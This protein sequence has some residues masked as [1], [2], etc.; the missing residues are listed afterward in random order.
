MPNTKIKTISQLLVII[1]LA[2]IVSACGRGEKDEATK[3]ST[4]AITTTT[5]HP[6]ITSEVQL[7]AIAFYNNDSTTD[8]T[9]SSSWQSSDEK[10][11]TINTTGLVTFLDAGE[12]TIS[13]EFN[14]KSGSHK[15]DVSPQPSI[16]TINIS[17]SSLEITET[18]VVTLSATG[19][20]TD[21]STVTDQQ[22]FEWRSSDEEIATIDNSEENKGVLTAKKYGTVT[23]IASS[24][25]IEGQMELTIQPEVTGINMDDSTLYLNLGDEKFVEVRAD[26]SN[27]EQ[28]LIT[29][30]L[31]WSYSLTETNTKEKEVLEIQRSGNVLL[32]KPGVTQVTATFISNT[33]QTFQASRTIVVEEPLNLFVAD[34][35]NQTIELNWLAVQDATEYKIYWS[36]EAN[37]TLENTTVVTIEDAT[38]F[39][40]SDVDK[41]QIYYYR[42]SFTR[43]GEESEP[44]PE[45][46]V[47]AH[48]GQWLNKQ[49]LA[50]FTDNA[51]G[52][53]QNAASVIHNDSIFVFGGRFY[54][55]NPETT[56]V[57]ESLP[58]VSSEVLEYR[59]SDDQWFP[60]SSLT[61]AREYA[62]ACI[63]QDMAFVIGGLDETDSALDLGTIS[64]F[65][66]VNGVWHEVNTSLAGTIL[67][68][69]SCNIIDN[70][71]YI[72]G[73]KNVDTA[74]NSVY[75]FDLLSVAPDAALQISALT[76]MNGARYNHSSTVLD[77]KIYVAG[78]QSGDDTL[79]TVEVYDPVENSWNDLKTMVNARHSFKLLSH[80]G[81]IYTIGGQSARLTTE[82]E[83][84][85]IASDNW[86]VNS[87]LPFTNHSFIGEI[88]NNIFYLFGGDKDLVS[89]SGGAAEHM[90]FS[91]TTNTWYPHPAAPTT[92]SSKGVRDFTSAALNDKLYLIGG[93]TET[94][95]SVS[96]V[97]AFDFISNKW[98]YDP[99]SSESINPDTLEIA[100]S[101]ATAVT[102]NNKIY[103]IGGKNDN[104]YLDTIEVYDPIGNLWSMS[105]GTLQEARSEACAVLFEQQ[106]YIFGGRDAGGL[107]SYE[108]FDPISE[109]STILGNT[110]QGIG[111]GCAVVNDKIY[112]IGGGEYNP[113]NNTV[114]ATDSFRVYTPAINHWGP[115]PTIIHDNKIIHPAVSVLNNRIYVFGGYKEGP[116]RT[117]IPNDKVSIYTPIRKTWTQLPSLSIPLDNVTSQV[118][119]NKIYIIGGDAAP[120]NDNIPVIQNN[121]YVFE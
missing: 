118:Y 58:T 35:I 82:A 106:I 14:G 107:L 98:N 75:S 95:T 113:V 78:G 92:T 62:T 60:K 10:I 69:A 52:V 121:V 32:N 36:N 3:L 102:Y 37:Q 8:V 84:Y 77:G 79:D 85:D 22:I 46:A 74:V 67:S 51:V 50:S 105:P 33:N 25:E 40:Q 87:N 57:V 119:K 12:V 56:E 93:N 53:I 73:G 76:P 108:R 38:E 9:A 7:T 68:N 24:G 18:D 5:T 15:F 96:N 55:D 86:Q 64:V 94:L 90:Q 61:Q 83:A 47:K 48:A 13:A 45:I 109:K 116:N 65:D 81:V 27:G 6:F 103:V 26:L 111:S 39:I 99:D 29:N 117:R 16:E 42:L 4:I 49:K 41:N 114:E 97:E 21:E 44:S 104:E 19:V 1:I 101:N 34:D 63:H 71:M 72:I 30:S 23:I 11:A 115:L 54:V 28:Q 91:L 120:N 20:L 17:S 43:N 112:I 110:V 100:R 70:T 89:N 59:F 88:H 80:D 2:V 66:T 31:N